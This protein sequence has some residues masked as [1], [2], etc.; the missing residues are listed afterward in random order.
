MSQVARAFRR[1]GGYSLE[2]YFARPPTARPGLMRGVA[3]P[4][5]RVPLCSRAKRE[6]LN[7][8]LFGSLDICKHH[9]PTITYVEEHGTIFIPQ[10][11]VGRPILAVP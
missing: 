2:A 5:W 7:S 9:D 1:A 3:G 4:P 8:D 10:P 11:V 6:A